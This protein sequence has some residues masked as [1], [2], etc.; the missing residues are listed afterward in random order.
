MI[1]FSLSW[2]LKIL[3]CLKHHMG[4]H[5]LSVLAHSEENLDFL[6]C[7]L[8]HWSLV[9]SLGN[10]VNTPKKQNNKQV[11]GLFYQSAHAIP[12][13]HAICTL[14][15]QKT[16]IVHSWGLDAFAAGP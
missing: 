15:T 13:I 10:A 7:C 5:L 6:L 3:A 11:C 16:P 1:S 2:H 14:I 4:S 12:G 8:L 9:G